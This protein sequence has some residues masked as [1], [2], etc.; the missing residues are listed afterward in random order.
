[1]DCSNCD[2]CVHNG[3]LTCNN[4]NSYYYGSYVRN[5]SE[6]EKHSEKEKIEM[7]KLRTKAKSML[8]Q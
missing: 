6:C 5:T 8:A 2:Y 4:E 3:W 1:M 7:D